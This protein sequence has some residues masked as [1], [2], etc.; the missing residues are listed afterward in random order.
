MRT[1]FGDFFRTL[2]NEIAN[3]GDIDLDGVADYAASTFET[4][5]EGGYVAIFSGKEDK[6]I[7]RLTTTKPVWFWSIA[8]PGDLNDDERADI[9]IGLWGGDPWRQGQVRVISGELFGGAESANEDVD[10]DSE[11]ALRFTLINVDGRSGQAAEFGGFEAFGLG[12]NRIG[13]INGDGIPDLGVGTGFNDDAIVLSGADGAR[14]REWTSDE[15]KLLTQFVVETESIGDV[16]GDGIR[17]VVVGRTGS[18]R[19][20]SGSDGALL[21]EVLEPERGDDLG[22]E[23]A[24]IGDLDGDG[25]SEVLAGAPGGGYALVI[26]FGPIVQLQITFED[27]RPV[28][29]WPPELAIGILERSFDLVTWE[30]VVE[31]DEV[32]ESRYPIPIGTDGREQYYRI[33]FGE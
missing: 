12:L 5:D 4:G 27:G 21:A 29:S 16:N 2:G 31:I 3:L 19:L 23:I 30:P 9:A 7:G 10:I 18:V 13:D 24:A 32:E 15:P 11:D 26:S 8:G 33:R 22:E 17:D 28:I 14:L 1:H 6:E 25:I 20:M